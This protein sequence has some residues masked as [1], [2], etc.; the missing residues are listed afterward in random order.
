[1]TPKQKARLRKLAD[2]LSKLKPDA[3]RKFDM[4]SWFE[5]TI[6]KIKVNPKTGV[7]TTVCGTSACALGHAALIPEFQ[8]AGLRL[9]VNKDGSGHVRYRGA[10]GT[11]AAE[12]FFGLIHFHSELLFGGIPSTPKKKAREIL[13]VLKDYQ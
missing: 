2:Y 8:K 13:E 3:H 10:T 11:E 9:V 5:T 4:G 12:T 1:M 7:C 6:E